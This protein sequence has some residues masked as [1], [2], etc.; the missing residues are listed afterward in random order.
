LFFLINQDPISI[1]F[2]IFLWSWMLDS[3]IVA[4]CFFYCSH[5][6]SALEVCC[7]LPIQDV[8]TR[9]FQMEDELHVTIYF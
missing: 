3:T 6:A 7:F 2:H 5:F 4:V 8:L 1:S 9:K